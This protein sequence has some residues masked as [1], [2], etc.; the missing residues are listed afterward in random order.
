VVVEGEWRE[1]ERVVVVWLEREECQRWER[2]GDERSL[3]RVWAFYSR[4][5]KF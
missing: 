3:G 2:G 1:R 4:H 5:E